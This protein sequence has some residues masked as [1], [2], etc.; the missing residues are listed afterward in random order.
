MVLTPLMAGSSRPSDRGAVIVLAR[1]VGR[2]RSRAVE[3]L[4]GGRPFS[5]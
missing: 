1:N 5:G 3:Q 2:R 4:Y